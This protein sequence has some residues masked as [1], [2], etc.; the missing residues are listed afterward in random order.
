M[1][2]SMKKRTPCHGLAAPITPGFAM[3]ERTPRTLIVPNQMSIVGPK[4]VPTRAVPNRCTMNRPNRITRVTGTTTCASAG[5]LTS[6][7]ST[8]PSTEMAGVI[9]PSP[10]RRAAPKSPSATSSNRRFLS[11]PRRFC[12][13]SRASR[14][15]IPPSPRLSARRMNTMYFTLT[16]R[17]SD[18]RISE[19]T[20][21]MFSGVGRIPYSALKHSRN[22]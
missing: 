14:A 12:W 18:Q 2:C 5:V 3:M 13:R 7:P 6:R 8:A 10:Y 9:T 19:R 22:A 20:P 16:T 11:S 4:A 21:R 1:P 17:I 15:R